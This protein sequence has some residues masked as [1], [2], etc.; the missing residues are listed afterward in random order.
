MIGKTF[1]GVRCLITKELTMARR[2]N[3]IYFHNA[4]EGYGVIMEELDEAREEDKRAKDAAESLLYAIRKGNWRRVNGLL[5]DMERHATLAACEY[6]QV[7]AMAQKMRES[8]GGEV[9]REQ[10]G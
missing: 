3:G 6:I 9:D 7:A 4:H 5:N 8:I 2:A 10:D 1:H